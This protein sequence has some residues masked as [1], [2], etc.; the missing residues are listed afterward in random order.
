MNHQRKKNFFL[1]SAFLL[2]LSF[3]GFA[4]EAVSL[5]FLPRE[6]GFLEEKR[7]VERSNSL[8]YYAGMRSLMENIAA[9]SGHGPE[10]SAARLFDLCG[11]APCS[12]KD[13]TGEYVIGIF[14]GPSAQIV[15]NHLKALETKL[16]NAVQ[17]K[18]FI[19]DFSGKKTP[20]EQ[21]Y[22]FLISHR[23]LDMVVYFHGG[24][25]PEM[26][27]LEPA[28]QKIPAVPE[29][30]SDDESPSVLFTRFSLNPLVRS[31]LTI[32]LLWHWTAYH[33]DSQ[34]SS[35]ARFI[36]KHNIP[37]IKPEELSGGKV[38]QSIYDMS[39]RENLRFNYVL[40]PH[41]FFPNSKAWTSEEKRNL[42]DAE[43][44]GDSARGA[45]TD[46]R[47]TAEALRKQNLSAYDLS[48]IYSSIPG[49][50][51]TNGLEPNKQGL[52]ILLNRLSG[53]IAGNENP[54]ALGR[55]NSA[56]IPEPAPAGEP[57]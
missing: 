31:S 15:T 1:A 42:S 51:W 13:I 11:R 50:V 41:P 19:V 56:S 27:G 25:T 8:S 49:S 14:G 45:Y 32:H 21:L 23:A 52:E 6:A 54:A 55:P 53:I 39:K 36:K 57:I 33:T 10:N 28:P 43:K 38:F 26:L 22:F 35:G 17:K 12:K 47:K 30:S 2:T 34:I 37:Q 16:E 7:A 20:L 46:L 18:V 3:A 40:L 29:V 24:Y 9:G 4:A 44:S 5:L 48:M